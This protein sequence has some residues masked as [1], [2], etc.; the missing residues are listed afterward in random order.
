MEDCWQ[1]D[2]SLRPSAFSL[3]RRLSQPSF[4]CHIASQVLRDCVAVR[5]CCFVPSVRQIWVYG[6]YDQAALDGE[7]MITEGTQVFIVNADNLTIQGSLEMKERVSSILAV[8]NKVWIGMTEACVHAYDTTTFQ[9][10]DR[11]HLTDSV[12]CI[13]SNDTYVFVGQAN[14]HLKCYRKLMLPKETQVVDIEV[15]DK[16]IIAMETV[17]DIVWLS[18]GNELVILSTEDE[19]TIETR[20]NAC[21][22]NDQVYALVLSKDATL[23]WSL[24]RGELAITC[25]DVHTGKLKHRGDLT[26]ELNWICCEINYDPTYLRLVSL[27]CVGDTLWLGL[28]C[29]VIV[30]LSAEEHPKVITNFRAHR[31]SPKCLLDIPLHSG[32]RDTHVVL[33]GGFGEILHSTNLITEQNGVIILWQALSVEQFRLVAQRHKEIQRLD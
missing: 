19:V 8:D 24:V 18:C 12:S 28:T 7:G 14:G 29:G 31:N 2:P 33:S 1:E 32:S 21:G 23:I 11:L 4:Q 9:F 15:G 17:G 10:T 26:G 16:A 6:E 22:E 30:I 25:W 20:W 13:A 5:G 27:E 3:L